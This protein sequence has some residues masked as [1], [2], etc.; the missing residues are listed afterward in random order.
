MSAYPVD[1]LWP[2]PATDLDLDAA[3]AGFGL[4]PAPAGRPLVGL[5]MVTTIDG[6]AQLGGRAEGLSGRVDR[7]LLQL[8]RVAYDAVGSGAGTLRADDFYSRLPADLAARRVA[9]GRPPQPTAVV[10][11]GMGEIPTDRRW[12]GYA[13][14]PRLLVIGAGA[15]APDLPA[16]IEVLVAPTTKPQPQ[17]LLGVIAERG[18]GSLLL[19]GGPTTNAAFL[20]ADVI[21]ELYWTLGAR[22]LGTD[23]LPMIA[24]IAGGSPWAER[25]REG[26]LVSVHRSGDELFLRYRFG[27]GAA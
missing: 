9:A 12:F 20:A 19:E 24:P 16:G 8:Y 18:V 21:D 4:P 23:A 15:E 26:R 2:D 22:L 11:G 7:R 27:A 3:L 13:E 25:P 14:Q 6:R 5:N 1:R 10:I 17:W